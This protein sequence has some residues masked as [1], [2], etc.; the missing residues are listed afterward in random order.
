MQNQSTLINRLYLPRSR[1]RSPL[2]HHS[3][4]SRRS[5]ILSLAS[6]T[7]KINRRAKPFSHS[8]SVTETNYKTLRPLLLLLRFL[9]NQ[10]LL[11]LPRRLL[12]PRLRSPQLH[13][14]LSSRSGILSLASIPSKINR[15]ALQRAATRCSRRSVRCGATWRVTRCRLRARTTAAP[16][17]FRTN[18]I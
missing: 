8:Q 15:R 10:S 18:R 17:V 13:D 7:S 14:R 9:Q 12:V 11:Y 1:S 4:H 6:I 3:D 16:S 5:G 2:P